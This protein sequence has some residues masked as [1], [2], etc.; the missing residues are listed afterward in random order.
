MRADILRAAKSEFAKKGLAGTS[1]KDIADR[2]QTSRRMIFYYFGDKEGLY[3]K[4]LEDAYS[5]IRQAE[6]E[7]HLDGLDP[8]EALKR[9]V[10]FTFDHHWRNSDFIRLVMGENIHD[11][12]YMKQIKS[13]HETNTKVIDQLT[14]ICNAGKKEGRFREDIEPLQLHWE[15]SALSFFNVSNKATF[16]I[17]FGDELYTD[18]GQ[19]ALRARI[20]DCVLCSVTPKT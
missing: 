13:M 10:E 19:A 8:L 18:E 11:G 6:M 14:R 2:I 1:V 17:N 16:S 9:L 15:I 7:L 3:R 12:H 5:S 4:V 20:V